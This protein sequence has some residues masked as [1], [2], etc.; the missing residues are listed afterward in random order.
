MESRHPAVSQDFVH[1]RYGRVRKVASTEQSELLIQIRAKAE[2]LTTSNNLFATGRISGKSSSKN[3]RG[4][5][6]LRLYV[7]APY[8]QWDG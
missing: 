7:A 3:G 2:K 4:Y 1:D 6:G 8:N 5:C